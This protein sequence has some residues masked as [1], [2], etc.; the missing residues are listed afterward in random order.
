M[1]TFAERL[2]KLRRERGWKKADMYRAMG[3]AP[4]TLSNYLSGKNSPNI[5]AV[6]EYSEKL[7]VSLAWLAGEETPEIGR[8][9]RGPRYILE[10]S[11]S[12]LLQRIY[13]IHSVVNDV[14]LVE[15]MDAIDVSVF[16]TF[17]KTPADEICDIE[18]VYE[19]R[20]SDI[21]NP[22]LFYTWGGA[23]AEYARLMRKIKEA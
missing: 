6:R 22:K 5:D 17:G 8:N 11:D 7:G 14:Y 20:L 13:Q 21:N 10:Y 9:S 19:L 23:L 4:G 3:I 16:G 15:I 12:G 18:S 1:A 2:E